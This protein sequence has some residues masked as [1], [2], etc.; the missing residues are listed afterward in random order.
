MFV[1]D[2]LMSAE[3][4]RV[5][6]TVSAARNPPGVMFTPLYLIVAGPVS[7]A[8]FASACAVAT[9]VRSDSLLTFRS[10]TVEFSELAALF[11]SA[12]VLTA[13]A[14]LLLASVARAFAAD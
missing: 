2:V 11:T 1:K 5:R 9:V 6:V 4:A 7:S 8:F 13:S 3:F 14:A 12:L 10:L